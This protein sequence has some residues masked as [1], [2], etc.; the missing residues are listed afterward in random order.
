ME[1][2]AYMQELISRMLDE[3]LNADEQAA[4][5]KHLESCPACRTMVEAFTA[6]SASLG[7]ELEE[8][9]ESL[10]E[11]VMAE[12]RR[13]EI[14]KKN[15]RPWRAALSVA[16]VLVLALG[17]RIG[18]GPR[19]GS[20]NMSAAV[21][22]MA[23]EVEESA[24]AEVPAEAGVYA[25]GAAEDAGAAPQAAPKAA[26]NAAPQADR[27]AEETADEAVFAEPVQ[28]EAVIEEPAAAL[29]VVPYAGS[30]WTA[31][32]GAAAESTHEEIDL[33]RLRYEELLSLLK[34]EPVPGLSLDEG[35][36]EGSLTILCAD[37]WLTLFKYGKDWYYY[38]PAD[39]TPRRSALGPEDLRTLARY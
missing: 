8:P 11:N 2:C 36:A 1:D 7:G 29:G 5:A 30:D 23:A 20:A 27:I 33:S 15:R 25:A 32:S 17:L 6:V 13:D 37:N 10:C 18:L 4:L 12:I 38:D 21:K 24:E 26:V 9:P 3:D 34:G 14:R 28:E 31:A 39:P 16:A 19:L 22:E 35:A